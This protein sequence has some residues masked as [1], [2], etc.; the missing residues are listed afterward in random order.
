MDA[1]CGAIFILELP[2]F[3]RRNFYPMT[4]IEISEDMPMTVVHVVHRHFEAITGGIGVFFKSKA[5]VFLQDG[6]A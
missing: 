5:M 3:F 4:G 6:F 2:I 1:R